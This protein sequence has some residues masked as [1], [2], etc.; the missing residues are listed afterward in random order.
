MAAGEVRDALKEGCAWYELMCDRRQSVRDVIGRLSAGEINALFNQLG[1]DEVRLLLRRDRVV[2]IL[3][4]RSDVSLLHHLELLAPNSIEPDI[5]NVREYREK[6]SNT[7]TAWGA[8]PDGR[9]FGTDGEPSL[10]HVKQGSIADCWWL[11]G[12]GALANSQEGRAH[13]KGMLSQNPNGTYTVTFPMEEKVTVTP[14][15]PIDEDG[16]LTFA[17]PDGR[18]PA[19]WPLV[20][21]KALA[22]KWGGYRRLVQ[23]DGGDAMEIL[24]GRHAVS[25]RPAVVGQAELRTAVDQGAVTLLTP[26]DGSADAIFEGR[27]A[28]LRTDHV[29]VVEQVAGD[30]RVKLYNPWGRDHSTITMEEFHR[31]FEDVDMSPIR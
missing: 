11:A 1:D 13:L 22:E 12:M 9:L 24:T 7:A 18:P 30:G 3:K 4:V 25:K 20:L 8:V 21:E 2:D 31:H 26:D 10:G 5:T 16:S 28:R 29:Y 6:P 17:Y 27:R 23:G 14:Y 15:F 19:I